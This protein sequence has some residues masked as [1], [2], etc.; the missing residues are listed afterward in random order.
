MT[1]KENSNRINAFYFKLFLTTSQLISS[2]WDGCSLAVSQSRWRGCQRG[3]YWPAPSEMCLWGSLWSTERVGGWGGSGWSVWLHGLSH[4]FC[5]G[6]FP[7]VCGWY[8]WWIFLH[9]PPFC[10]LGMRTGVDQSEG[11]LPWWCW[12][13]WPTPWPSSPGR[14]EP[15]AW[16]RSGPLWCPFLGMGITIEYFHI[17]GSCGVVEQELENS[18]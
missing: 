7:G 15:Q 1:K 13:L 11:Q 16:G 3:C 12:F 10:L 6:G 2:V 14:W 4:M 9:H 5:W 17:G 18:H 8:Q